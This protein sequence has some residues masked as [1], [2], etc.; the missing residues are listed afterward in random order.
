MADIKGLGNCGVCT[1][2]IENGQPIRHFKGY[3]MAHKTCMDT[4]SG[5][6]AR[7]DRARETVARLNG[8]IGAM[9]GDRDRAQAV[10]DELSRPKV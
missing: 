6:D 1:Q 9:T 3:V 7:L 2:A 4:Y 8:Q 10:I 5:D